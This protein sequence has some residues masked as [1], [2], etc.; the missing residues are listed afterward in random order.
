MDWFSF[1][2][3]VGAFLFVNVVYG[4][5]IAPKVIKQMQ[6]SEKE[7]EETFSGLEEKLNLMK[8]EHEES[9]K[10][11][12]LRAEEMRLELDKQTTSRLEFDK[13]TASVKLRKT[14]PACGAEFPLYI[15]EE[16]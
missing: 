5:W 7:T 3:G 9:M 14:C 15:M 6:K 10:L 12:R 1:L 2:W 4:L 8:F 16:E 13:L 11:W